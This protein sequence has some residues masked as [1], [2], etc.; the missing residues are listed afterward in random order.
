MRRL[1]CLVVLALVVGCGGDDSNAPVVPTGN[2]YEGHWVGAYGDQA[3]SGGYVGSIDMTIDGA[4]NITGFILW[5]NTDSPLLHLV[6][7]FT[8]GKVDSQG[9]ATITCER[10][11]QGLSHTLSLTFTRLINT[12]VCEGTIMWDGTPHAAR[13]DVTK[14]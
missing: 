11:G 9:N 6:Y 8:S 2:P 3:H 10:A 12:M 1:L 14:Q 5:T 7:E 13:A 4:G